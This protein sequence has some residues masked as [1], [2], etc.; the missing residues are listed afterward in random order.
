MKIRVCTS[1]R[2]SRIDQIYRLFNLALN[3]GSDLVEIRLDYIQAIDVEELKGVLKSLSSYIVT[4]RP[5][6]E[7][8]R[9]KKSEEERLQILSS[10]AG[11][12]PAYVDLE[13]KAI[14]SD[15]RWRRIVDPLNL[16]VSYH[17]FDSTPETSSLIKIWEEASNLKGLVKI[18]TFA[19]TYHDNF[20][21]LS[22]YRHVE[23]ERL[24]AFCMGSKGT[25]SRVLCPILGGPFTYASLDKGK[26]AAGQLSI[27]ILKELYEVVKRNIESR[28]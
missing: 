15:K 2:P 7:G 19:R 9:F 6:W 16:I 25:L 24:I 21:V 11:V 17:D 13:L 14:R 5:S 20:K 3:K 23:P 10:L 28:S 22:L 1:I 8:G 12:K 26:T 18:V 4:C 27:D